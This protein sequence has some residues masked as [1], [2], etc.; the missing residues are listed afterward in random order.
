MGEQNRMLVAERK[1]FFVN[2]Y[3]RMILELQL[4]LIYA[5][6]LV[7]VTWHFHIRSFFS[8]WVIVTWHIQQNYLFL[9]WVGLYKN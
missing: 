2:E 1:D 9:F 8:F 3:I 7:S 6:F 5:F 4:S